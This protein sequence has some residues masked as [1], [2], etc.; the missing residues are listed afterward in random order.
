MLYFLSLTCQYYFCCI[1]KVIAKETP[2]PIVPKLID[3]AP[4][5]SSNISSLVTPFTNTELSTKVIR[6]VSNRLCTK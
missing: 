5:E 1:Q 2:T 6:F 4:I 3:S